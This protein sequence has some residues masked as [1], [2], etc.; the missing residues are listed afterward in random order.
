MD[1]LAKRLSYMIAHRGGIRVGQLA[2]LSGV[3]QANISRYR[4]GKRGQSV[5]PAYLWDIALVLRCSFTWLAT[6]H[7][8]PYPGYRESLESYR[9]PCPPRAEA[10]C[11]FRCSFDD[12]D[13]VAEVRRMSTDR[14]RTAAGWYRMLL[15]I[16]EVNHD[17]CELLTVAFT[18]GERREDWPAEFLAG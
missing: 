10:V 14:E 3:S 1:T 15:A 5:N 16:A 2:E 4:N 7:G 8:S 11:F 6:G 9:D 12:E 18:S 17:M 13:A